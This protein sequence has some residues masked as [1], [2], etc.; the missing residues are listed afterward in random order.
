MADRSGSAINRG[1]KIVIDEL[2][3]VIAESLGAHTN[4]SLHRGDPWVRG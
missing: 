3:G 2:V 1:R 4:C